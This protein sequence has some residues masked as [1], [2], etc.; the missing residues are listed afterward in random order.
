MHSLKIDE[1]KSKK[2]LRKTALDFKLRRFLMVVMKI[3]DT[4]V[5]SLIDYQL[6]LRALLSYLFNHGR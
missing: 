1:C 3:T 2:P 5:S 6:Y 4:D